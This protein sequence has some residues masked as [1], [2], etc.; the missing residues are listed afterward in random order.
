MMLMPQLLL[1][2]LTISAQKD[3]NIWHFGT[4]KG[5]SIDFNVEPPK[6][7]DSPIEKMAES[8]ASICDPETGEIILYCNDN[9]IWNSKNLIVKD[10]T[11]LEG[12][13]STAQG[14][15]IVPHPCGCDRYIVFQNDIGEFPFTI[16]DYGLSYSIVDMKLENSMGAVTEKNIPISN[17]VAEPM[18]AVKDTANGYWLICH[19][20]ESHDYIVYHIG[21]EGIE[22]DFQKFTTNNFVDNPGQGS[23]CATFDGNKIAMGQKG[24]PFVEILD[25]DIATGKLTSDTTILFD[26][27]DPDHQHAIS[28]G[29][30]PNGKMLYTVDFGH[31]YQFDFTD[32]NDFK[33]NTIYRRDTSATLS[34]FFFLEL[35]PN[36]KIYASIDDIFSNADFL[37]VIESPNQAFPDCT[38]NPFALEIPQSSFAFGFPAIIKNVYSPEYQTFD[39]N[40]YF[41]IEF[42][43]SNKVQ[44]INKSFNIQSYEWNLGDGKLSNE[45]NFN[46]I[47]RDTGEYL[48]R[49]TGTNKYGC[50]KTVE[51]S[52][53]INVTTDVPI[54]NVYPNP[55]SNVLKIESSRAIKKI[56]VHSV[57]GQIILEKKDLNTEYVE[58]DLSEFASQV[59]IVTIES[60]G[61]ELKKQIIKME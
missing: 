51:K 8:G 42:I 23:L 14:S 54:L 5:V 40:V 21:N 17:K 25:F 10:A 36:G 44:L 32:E 34:A 35:A 11:G 47:Y 19:E 61:K 3:F 31:L 16:E 13:S 1:F 45:E 50:K 46:H 38:F 24:N 15:L 27:G 48:I 2:S 4:W 59:Y 6:V 49:L 33:R 52:L 22:M 18:I 7:M 26:S 53:R 30:S 43:D 9:T 56:E 58:L 12:S 28:V 57:S 60:E 39:Y 20:I 41:D 37:G 29:F 55:T